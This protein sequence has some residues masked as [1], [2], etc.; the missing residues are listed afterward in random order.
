MLGEREKEKE[1]ERER[2]REGGIRRQRGRVNVKNER[3]AKHPIKR[4]GDDC[5]SSKV[6]LDKMLLC[7]S[8]GWYLLLP[9]P[10][11]EY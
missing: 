11:F 10:T 3:A 9:G 5:H 6:F 4:K 2:E 8:P 7:L 1:R